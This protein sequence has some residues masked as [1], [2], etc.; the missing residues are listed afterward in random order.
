MLQVK[1]VFVSE[2]DLMPIGELARRT[3]VAASALR[4]YERIGLLSPA[5]R[6]GRQRRYTAS[7]QK[8]VALI[9]LCKDAGFTL[10]ETRRLIAL[11]GRGD[12]RWVPMARRKI[13][14]LDARIA[15]ARR[16]RDLIRHGLD[17]PHGDVRTCPNFR[18]ALSASG[19]AT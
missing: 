10:A 4:Y 9:G 15:R 5:G 8:R 17:C 18:S 19:R 13:G 1:G 14:E 2:D 12:R 3:G 6:V 11:M 16:A 7:S